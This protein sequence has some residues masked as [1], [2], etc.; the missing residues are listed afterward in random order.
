MNM[1][2][3]K[4]FGRHQAECQR[5]SHISLLTLKDNRIK[6]LERQLKE[7]R[8]LRSRLFIGGEYTCKCVLRYCN[9]NQLNIITK[10]TESEVTYKYLSTNINMDR[11]WDKGTTTHKRFLEFNKLKEKG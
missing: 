6:H 8:E 3:G 10:L 7:A 5:Q 2:D 9:C 4:D 1:F 11:Y